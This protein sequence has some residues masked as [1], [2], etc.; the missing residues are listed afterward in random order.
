MLNG[1]TDN[2][3]ADLILEHG[4]VF[5]GDT[6]IGVTVGG[7]SFDP[8]KEMRNVQYDGKKSDVVGLHRID[9]YTPILS[10]S[11][12]EFGGDTT[13][14]QIRTLEAGATGPAQTGGVDSAQGVV[15][16]FTPKPAGTFFTESE[17]ADDIRAVFEHGS[18][19]VAI[20]FP[21][22][23]VRKYGPI[24]GADKNEAKVPF[25]FVGCLSQD[26]AVSDPGKCPYV[27]ELRTARPS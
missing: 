17:Y 6:P 10:G 3:P 5:R 12:I 19:Y 13:G 26:D 11:L 8:G 9:S 20:L 1:Q 16:T 23:F 24:Q 22:A 27:I 21:H 7:V 25:E 18:G 15:R 14:D 2:L 4:V